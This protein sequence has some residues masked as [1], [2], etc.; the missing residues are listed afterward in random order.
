MEK[1]GPMVVK[2][3]DVNLD[4]DYAQWLNEIK[5]R[6][7][8][9]QIKAAV[10][11]NAEQLLFNWQLGRD[12]VMR[13]A[14]EK[15]GSGIVEQVSL[16]LQAAF[17][18]SKGFSATNLWRMKH[19][20]T[21]YSD[22]LEKLPQLVKEFQKT[23]N[24]SNIKLPQVV[25]EFNAGTDASFPKIFACVPWGHHIEIITKCK[26]IKEALFYVV[27]C[28]YKG[29]S[30]HTLENCLH[31]HYYE[32]C[33]GAITNFPEKLP[34]PQSEMAQEITKD[35][36]D[37]G[38]LSLP[39]G[40]DEEKLETELE[41]QLTRFLLELGT[42]FAYLGRQKQIIVAGKTRKLDMLF[43]HINL[44]CYIVIELKAVPFQP[45]FAGKLNFYV[46]AVNDLIK[47][48]S[49]NPTIGLLIC[50]GKDNTEVQYAFNGITTPMGVASYDNVQIQKL[51]EQLPSVEELKAR[52]RLL[53]EELANKK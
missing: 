36:Y 46:N 49:Q 25:E 2:I 30:R 7:R 51:Q 53:E 21:F 35:T 11:V 27:Q 39:D 14:E 43:F 50:K 8:S 52:I 40:Y 26:D 16:D 3:H 41:K 34:S 6:Y 13:K 31:A 15:W 32:S 22:A 44:N 23:E 10:K 29:W 5:S 28:A 20:Y 33:G 19:W 42:G 18:E 1:N 37:F 45:E 17:S 9:S 4:S 47:T 12:L 48:P 38:F 24:Q